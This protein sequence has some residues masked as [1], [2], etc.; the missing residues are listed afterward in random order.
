MSK[1]K[2]ESA[3][4]QVLY[5]PGFVTAQAIYANRTAHLTFYHLMQI[6][7]S[8]MALQTENLGFIDIYFQSNST[9]FL[10]HIQSYLAKI[11]DQTCL[12]KDDTIHW[13]PPRPPAKA[14]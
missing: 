1:R 10:L 5:K 6:G 13:I 2:Y 7:M 3:F 11:Y 4:F 12:K 14:A 9:C 8:S